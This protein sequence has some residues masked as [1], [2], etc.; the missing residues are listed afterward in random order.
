MDVVR[1]DLGVQ[2]QEVGMGLGPD[3]GGGTGFSLLKEG[4]M[5]YQGQMLR[6]GGVPLTPARLLWLATRSGAEA[7]GLGNEVGDFRAGKAADV[8]ALRAP[9]GSTLRAVLRE[10]PD[11]PA[12]LVALFT[13]AREDSVQTV[14]VEG[15]A[16]FSRGERR[17]AEQHAA[18]SY[19]RSRSGR[20]PWIP[21]WAWVRM[22]FARRLGRVWITVL[23]HR[24]PAAS[25]TQGEANGQDTDGYPE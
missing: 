8:V 12:A 2:R 1:M 25:A 11:P 10:A 22:P 6:D 9:E 13:L 14:W 17:S 5:A 20:P 19:C 23:G 7:L 16:V 24:F 21:D 15:E 4:L 18:P 3:V